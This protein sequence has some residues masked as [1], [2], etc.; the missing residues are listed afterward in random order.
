LKRDD[1]A[2][3]ISKVIARIRAFRAAKGWSV[4]RM[5][6][7]AGIRESTLRKMDRDDWNPTK[8]VLERLEAV[9]PEH[10]DPK[11]PE[12]ADSPKDQAA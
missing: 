2:M 4:F 1:A 7:E 9:I 10:F 8:E 6:T 3:S 5:G 12:T 11:R